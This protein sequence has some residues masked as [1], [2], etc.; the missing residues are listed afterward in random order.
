MEALVWLARSGNFV[1]DKLAKEMVDAYRE[2][3]VPDQDLEVRRR[4]M[5]QVTESSAA[6]TV[7]RMLKNAMSPSAERDLPLEVRS[8]YREAGLQDHIIKAKALKMPLRVLEL[9]ISNNE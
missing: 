5:Y 1:S 6:I 7:T 4:Y 9:L 8:L 3:E 2:T